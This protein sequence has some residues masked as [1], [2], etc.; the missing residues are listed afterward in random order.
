[1]LHPH[2]NANYFRLKLGKPGKPE[3]RGCNQPFDAD[4]PGMPFQKNDF[5]IKHMAKW[6]YDPNKDGN[7]RLSPKREYRSWK[8]DVAVLFLLNCFLPH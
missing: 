7:R 8:L 2:W 4:D 6:T 3:C 1:M 5:A